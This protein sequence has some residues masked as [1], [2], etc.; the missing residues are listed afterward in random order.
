MSSRGGGHR[1][2]RWLWT[3][4]RIDARLFRLVLLPLAGLWK[5]GST[6]RNARYD[7]GTAPVASLPLPT[8]AVGNLSVGGS[9]KTPVAGWVAHHFASRGRIPGILTSGYGRDEALLHQQRIP[10]AR[11]HDTVRRFLQETHA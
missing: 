3:S 5:L 6:L 10:T 9:G 2:L 4:R 7:R 11:V 1:F 8:I